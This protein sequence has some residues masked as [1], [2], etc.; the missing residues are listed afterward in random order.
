MSFDASLSGPMETHLAHQ[1]GR[2][3]GTGKMNAMFGTDGNIEASGP[4][5]TMLERGVGMMDERSMEYHMRSRSPLEINMD[6]MSNM[7][8]DS[9][10]SG[11]E[12]G[13]GSSMTM[14]SQ[15]S[16]SLFDSLFD[17]QPQ[18]SG[19]LPGVSSP[20]SSGAFGSHSG[21]NIQQGSILPSSQNIVSDPL[22]SPI[23]NMGVHSQSGVHSPTGPEI[24]T[25]S[26]ATSQHSLMPGRPDERNTPPQG[27]H[28]AAIDETPIPIN[29]GSSSHEQVGE[30]NVTTPTVIPLGGQTV[31][32]NTIVVE[33]DEEDDEE[34]AALAEGIEHD[35]EEL[36]ESDTLVL[37]GSAAFEPGSLRPT[38]VPSSVEELKNKKSN[39]L[40]A[41]QQL[42][43][44]LRRLSND[45]LADM[46]ETI[47][48]E[49]DS[50]T[51][52]KTFL[53]NNTKYNLIG[54]E[55]KRRVEEIA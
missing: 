24:P 20:A 51:D 41:E 29:F 28:Q 50:A 44:K 19:P 8:G 42:A 34:S 40:T 12:G 52:V 55:V 17:S 35:A 45:V 38:L 22:H 26:E 54:K 6:A 49:R 14:P 15:N 16:S 4:M 37:T 11:F 32:N 23:E 3:H 9:M 7:R 46:T 30:S 13:F 2:G 10:S 43:N 39:A 25:V 27:L 47:L 33:K 53:L 31:I 36:E 5:G 18:M 48:Q 21:M 1:V